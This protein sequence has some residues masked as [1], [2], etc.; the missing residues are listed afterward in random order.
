MG[1][2]Q[3]SLGFLVAFVTV[4]AFALPASAQGADAAFGGL[5]HDNSLP[6]EITADALSLDQSTGS[7]IFEGNVLVGQ[8]S[9]R[10][11]ADKLLVKYD[12]SSSTGRVSS[13]IA[14]GHVLLTNGAEAAEAS[15]AVYEVAGGS[16]LMNGNVLLTQG[17]NALSGD[18]LNINLTTGQAKME[19]RVK[20]IFQPNTN[21]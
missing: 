18:K 5:S 12:T 17:G 3:R 9:L 10:L 19:G 8:G 13:M 20:T 1:I 7:A 11:K 2:L 16:V 15:H 6:V 14:D 4:V 21:E